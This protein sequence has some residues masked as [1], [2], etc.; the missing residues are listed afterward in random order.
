[1]MVTNPNSLTTANSSTLRKAKPDGQMEHRSKSYSST[2]GSPPPVTTGDDFDDP[3]R[4]SKR[5]PKACDR[6]RH[7]KTKVCDSPLDTHNS[8]ANGLLLTIF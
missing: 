1:M 7:K 8:L 2:T 6:C 5:T 3:L 4:S